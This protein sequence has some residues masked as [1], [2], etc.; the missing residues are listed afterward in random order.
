MSVLSPRFLLSS[1]SEKDTSLPL[2][3]AGL[4]WVP[5][6]FPPGPGVVL[7]LP[8]P[9]WFCTTGF[10]SSTRLIMVLISSGYWHQKP[11]PKCLNNRPLFS[12][13]PEAER[14]KIKVPTDSVSCES[15]L[16][17]LQLAVFLLCPL[18]VERERD[19][20]RGPAHDLVL[21]AQLYLSF[22][23]PHGQSVS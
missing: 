3:R 12:T 11:Q 10:S 21:V 20:S 22:L 18:V 14:A 16:L 17:G 23:R 7:H 8:M 5:A 1:V 2:S 19:L 4:V 15:P 13:V 9:L 6:P